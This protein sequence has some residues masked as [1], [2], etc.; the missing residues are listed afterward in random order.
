MRM[1]ESG[2]PLPYT[3]PYTWTGGPCKLFPNSQLELRVYRQSG[4]DLHKVHMRDGFGSAIAKMP[5]PNAN[6]PILFLK[7][8]DAISSTEKEMNFEPTP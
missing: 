5:R 8:D 7:P 4:E 6:D 2:R 1:G 3:F